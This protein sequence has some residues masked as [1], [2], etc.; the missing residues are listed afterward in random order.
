MDKRRVY[1]I[2]NP[3][4]SEGVIDPAHSISP[5]TGHERDYDPNNTV[6]IR[7][8]GSRDSIISGSKLT[9]LVYHQ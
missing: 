3:T 8:D 1:S 5:S 2:T 7:I 6:R 4:G 9:D